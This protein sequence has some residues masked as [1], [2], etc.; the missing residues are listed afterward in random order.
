[1]QI[2]IMIVFDY[3]MMNV[4]DVNVTLLFLHS[5]FF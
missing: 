1:M 5:A 2:D 4:S 3:A